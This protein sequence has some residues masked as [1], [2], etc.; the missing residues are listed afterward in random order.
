MKEGEARRKRD[1]SI[2]YTLDS[3]HDFPAFD[4]CRGRVPESAISLFYRGWGETTR[5]RGVGREIK[6]ELRQ[7]EISVL[8]FPN[9]VYFLLLFLI[10]RFV[11]F[12]YYSVGLKLIRD[13]RSKNT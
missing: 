4:G 9:F 7:R 8:I 1:R 2:F 3:S 10:L 5:E 13:H 6:R 11:I 12:F